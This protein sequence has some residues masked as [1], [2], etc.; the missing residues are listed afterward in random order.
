MVCY[1]AVS[2]IVAQRAVAREKTFFGARI[3][4]HEWQSESDLDVTS[5]I[6]TQQTAIPLEM[7]LSHLGLL[8]RDSWPANLT[9][10]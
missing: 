6:R 8:G 4:T 5:G 9:T 7:H 3:G 2:S 10:R 1:G